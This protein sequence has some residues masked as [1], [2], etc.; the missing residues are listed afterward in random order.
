ME[1]NVYYVRQDVT[2]LKWQ[3]VTIPL[4]QGRRMLERGEKVFF[5]I[6]QAFA[7]CRDLNRRREGQRELGF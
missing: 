4:D 2:T 3:V 5:T 7:V 6:A 1:G